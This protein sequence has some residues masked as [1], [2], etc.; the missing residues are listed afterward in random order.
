VPAGA[1]ATATVLG[2]G[3]FFMTVP[4]TA[5]ALNAEFAGATPAASLAGTVELQR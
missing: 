5:A 3:R 2:V 4:A 1:T